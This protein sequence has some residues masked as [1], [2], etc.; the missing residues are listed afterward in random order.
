MCF[1][2][3]LGSESILGVSR[4]LMVLPI[5]DF[6]VTRKLYRLAETCPTWNDFAPLSVAS[7]TVALNHPQNQERALNLSILA[8]SGPGKFPRVE[9]N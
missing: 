4:N 2:L 9:S 6:V 8:V 3:M 1:P 5:G 7:A